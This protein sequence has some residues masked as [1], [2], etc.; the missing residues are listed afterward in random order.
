M[1]VPA[2]LVVFTTQRSG[3][4]FLGSL[5]LQSWTYGWLGEWLNPPY[6]IDERQRIGISPEADLA[7]YLGAV[8]AARRTPEKGWAIKLM[9]EHWERARVQR[10]KDSPNGMGEGELFRRLFPEIVP[11]FLYR[12]DTVAQAVSLTIAEQTNEWRVFD[13]EE[14]YSGR[15]PV[16]DRTTI[17]RNV[18]RLESENSYW[19][20]FFEKVQ[21][22]PL[23]IAYEALVS[24]PRVVLEEILSKGPYSFNAGKLP[25]TST[26][27]RQGSALNLEWIR[28]FR[29]GE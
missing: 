19:E 26:T 1:K 13:G 20:V 15:E 12:R 9:P 22:D 5:I 2:A 23:R 27:K 24:N 6:E 25:Q 8:S 7:T 16:Y 29:D 4:N 14:T 21:L 11:V 17:A 18:E 10:L 3:S 28:R